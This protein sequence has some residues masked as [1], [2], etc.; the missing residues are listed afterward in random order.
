M[1][2]FQRAVFDKDTRES[3]GP[4]RTMFALARK[5]FIAHFWTRPRRRSPRLPFAKRLH[6][7]VNRGISGSEV[8]YSTISQTIHPTDSKSMRHNKNA[9]MPIMSLLFMLIFDNAGFC[10]LRERS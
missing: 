1:V 6:R 3:R 7:G 2:W 10:G 4:I 8:A 9:R 5:R